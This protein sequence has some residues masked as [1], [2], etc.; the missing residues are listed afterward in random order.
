VRTPLSR[1]RILGAALDIVDREGVEA[2]S[3][4]RLGEALG[5]E[6][7]SLYN[8]FASK[9]DIL[10]GIFER[11]VGDLPT[12]PATRSWLTAMRS[13]CH[14]LRAALRRHPNALTLFATRPAVTPGSLAQVEQTLEILHRAGFTAEHALATLHIVV[15][16]IVGH[17]LSSYGPRRIEDRA[18]REYGRVGEASLPRV[19]DGVRI[20]AKRD[21]EAEFDLGLDA[22]LTA[23]GSSRHRSRRTRTSGTS[24]SRR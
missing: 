16:F 12:P 5:V 19:R 8:H 7:M 2:I 20:L 24:R 9:A 21:V 11:V 6:A 3:M 18:N 4:R 10:D 15:A 22:L 1:D 17:T 23:L 13:R 14:D